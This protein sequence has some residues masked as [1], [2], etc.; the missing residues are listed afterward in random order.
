MQESGNGRGIS[1]SSTELAAPEAAGGGSSTTSSNSNNKQ[2]NNATPAVKPKRIKKS[3]FTTSCLPCQRRKRKCDNG[4]PCGSCTKRG[5]DDQCEY[6]VVKFEDGTTAQLEHAK[7]KQRVMALEKA[8]TAIQNRSEYQSAPPESPTY[9]TEGQTEQAYPPHM[10]FNQQQV[11][12]SLAILKDAPTS[13]TAV[14][15]RSQPSQP[16]MAVSASP[17]QNFEAFSNEHI[18]EAEVAAILLENKTLGREQYGMLGS[19]HILLLAN[20]STAADQSPSS[21]ALTLPTQAPVDGSL[22]TIILPSNGEEDVNENDMSALLAAMPSRRDS[23]ILVEEFM[24]DVNWIYNV[25]HRP[26]FMQEVAELWSCVAEGNT[27]RIDP[28]WLSLYFMV[29]CWGATTL[30]PSKCQL[31]A[32]KNSKFGKRDVSDYWRG[33]AQKALRAAEWVV[34]PQI[35]T[36]Q[37]ICLLLNWQTPGAL[38]QVSDSVSFGIWIAAGI[39]IAQALNIHRLPEGDPLYLM[40]DPAFPR[41]PSSIKTEVCRRIWSLLTSFDWLFNS[42][43]DTNMIRPSTFTTAQPRKVNDEDIGLTTEV[44][45]RSR[46]EL[47]DNDLHLVRYQL[48]EFQLAMSAFL[49]TPMK[50]YDMILDLDSR[51]QQ[52]V[53]TLPTTN[54][55]AN[56]RC[57]PVYRTVVTCMLLN[58]VVRLH[59]PFLIKGLESPTSKY[60]YSAKICISSARIM[61]DSLDNGA[62]SDLV[63][64]WYIYGQVLGAVICIFIEHLFASAKTGM[65]TQGSL[66]GDTSIASA[67]RFFSRG[68]QSWSNTLQTISRQALIVMDQFSTLEYRLPSIRLGNGEPFEK[69]LAIILKQIASAIDSDNSLACVTNLFNMTRGLPRV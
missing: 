5:E 31:N 66:S 38:S 20:M 14:S 57:K 22:T 2:G 30:D 25:I 9:S 17:A 51:L 60:A 61:C 58:R 34:R 8:L 36:L 35:R 52:V 48:A 46:E 54:Y 65:S 15:H 63:V 55:S 23:D 40:N 45:P 32:V 56:G 1:P 53:R 26:T 37:A 44:H 3:R 59:R 62:E 10:A 69:R 49:E 33:A 6:A 7:L 67:R 39:R 13:S 29:L 42:R 28:A 47:T 18:D 43:S 50:S 68:L 27:S 4:V 41:G 19:N 21:S 16:D 11:F 12:S 64:F 24:K